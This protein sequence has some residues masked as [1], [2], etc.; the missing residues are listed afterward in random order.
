MATKNHSKLQ[1]NVQSIAFSVL[2]L[3]ALG[4]RTNTS[5]NFLTV[6]T[7]LHCDSAKA[8]RVLF[9]SRITH[10]PVNGRRPNGRHRQGVTV[11]K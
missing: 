3:L 4:T 10:Q 1:N 7:T 2:S 11:L 9:V 6:Y 8:V 5:F